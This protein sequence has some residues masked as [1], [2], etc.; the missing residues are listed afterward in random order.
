MLKEQYL[1]KIAPALKEQLKKK[2]ALEV[3]TIIKVTLNSGLS[4]KRDPKFI[5][6]ITDTLKKIS[7]Q[8]PVITKARKSESGFKVREGMVVGAMVTLRGTHMWDFIDKLVHVDFPRVRDFRG[9]EESTVDKSGNFNYGFTEHTAFPE[10]SVDEIESIH[11]LQ[12]S[13]TTTASTHEEGLALF[14][15]LGFPFKKENK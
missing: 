13:I 8:Q 4:A 14:K 9:I 5:D 12:V 3:P 10:I 15:A 6:K 11:G 7:G 2:N 1:T